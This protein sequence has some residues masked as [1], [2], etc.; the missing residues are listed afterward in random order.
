MN[1]S[2]TAKPYFQ[3]VEVQQVFQCLPASVIGLV[4]EC[5]LAVAVHRQELPAGMYAGQTDPAE[6]KAVGQQPAYD[7]AQAA[8]AAADLEIVQHWSDALLDAVADAGA[9]V[10][11]TC[12][13]ALMKPQTLERDDLGSTRAC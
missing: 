11:A 13:S 10:V 4:H 12:R 8:T 7:S 2:F 6:G 3:A 1:K 9:A 5:H